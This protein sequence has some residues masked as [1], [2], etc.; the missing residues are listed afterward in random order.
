MW[1]KEELLE[2][3]LKAFIEAGISEATILDSERLGG[4]LAYE[5]PLFAGFKDFLAGNKPY[6][7]TIFSLVKNE[8]TVKKLEKLIENVCGSFSERRIGILFSV[9]VDF[10]REFGNE[11]E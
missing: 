8:D 2:E 4:F 5:V 9:P 7:R 1:N 10:T 6:N 11:G 3:V